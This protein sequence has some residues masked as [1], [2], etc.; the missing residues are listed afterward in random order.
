MQ[1]PSQL[2]GKNVIDLSLQLFNDVEDAKNIKTITIPEK[3]GRI[4]VWN[5]GCYTFDGCQNLENIQVEDNNSYLSSSDGL[6]FDKNKTKLIKCPQGKTTVNIPNTVTEI[7]KLAFS[8]CDKITTIN[9]P[10]GITNIEEGVFKNC[11]SLTN[12][13]IP[14]SVTMISPSAF[15]GCT[16]LTNIQIPDSVKKIYEYTFKNCGDLKIK[17]PN[18]VESINYSAFDDTNVTII[19]EN[20]SKAHEF[21]K[22]NNIKYTLINTVNCENEE[23]YNKLK[24]QISSE[25]IEREDPENLKLLIY[26]TIENLDI[27]NLNLTNIDWIKDFTHLTSLNASSNNIKDISPL[28]NL[29]ITNLNLKN[30]AIDVEILKEEVQ[31]PSILSQVI[32]EKYTRWRRSNSCFT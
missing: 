19:C 17:I 32:N 25:Y 16:S 1:I 31:I 9:I 8:G 14:D 24:E 11:T 10:D 4:N 3:V 27:S 15:E 22:N 7:N 30:Q 18:G 12:V 2:N 6:I 20:G 28:D 21:A 26:D 13:R 29:T 23:L 5:K